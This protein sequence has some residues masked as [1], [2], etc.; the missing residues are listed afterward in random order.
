M[1]ATHLVPVPKYWL[2]FLFAAFVLVACS[3]ET[4][5][6]PETGPVI[7]AA[8]AAVVESTID[9]FEI[10]NPE[11]GEEL[12]NSQFRTFCVECHTL[13]GRTHRPG[14]TLLGMSDVAGRRVPG[15]S[16]VEYVRQSMVA[17][18]AY[19]VAG[20][21]DAPKQME[22]Y[23]I[24]EPD[25]NGRMEKFTLTEEELNDLIAFVLTQ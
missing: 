12:F 14:P 24:A 16:A 9:P 3:G 4:T 6:E 22:I 25:E 11:A 7:E 17:P 15:L 13:D 5:G 20:F 23:T 18:Q 19:I 8:G 21:E 10:G 1:F 2:A